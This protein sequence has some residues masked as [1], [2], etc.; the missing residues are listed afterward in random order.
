LLIVVTAKVEDW[1]LWES[2]TLGGHRVSAPSPLATVA[3]SV[4]SSETSLAARLLPWQLQEPGSRYV[5]TIY[6]YPSP[7]LIGGPSV[8]RDFPQ[9]LPDGSYTAPARSQS[10]V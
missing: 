5:Q 1:S 7:A 10:P 8:S 2:L 9:L 4:S 6:P 3:P